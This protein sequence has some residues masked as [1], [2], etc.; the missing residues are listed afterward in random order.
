MVPNSPEWQRVRTFLANNSF[1]GRL[2]DGVLDALMHKGKIRRHTK[3]AIIFRR[4]E[5]GDSLLV[6]TCGQAKLTSISPTAREI[7]MHFV[8]AGDVFGETSALDGKERAVTAVALE[9]LEVFI[10]HSRDLLPTLTAHPG[11]MLAVVHALCETIRRGAAV[12]EDNTLEMRGRM[13]RGLLR[14]A[15][16]HGRADGDGVS[17]ALTISQ[18]DLGKYLD[19]SRANVSRQLGHLKA[20]GVLKIDGTQMTIVDADELAAIGEMN[21]ARDARGVG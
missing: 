16:Q 10:I 20:A 12:I 2:P 6:L 3:G 19:L 5:P 8:G 9:D 13:A 15:R 4:G 14:L 18:E 21:P 7:V 11:A 17:L 1:L